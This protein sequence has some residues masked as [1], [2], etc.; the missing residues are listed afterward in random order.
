MTTHK[1]PR[2]R[3]PLARRGTIVAIAAGVGLI[4]PAALSAATDGGPVEAGIVVQKVEGLPDDFAAGVDVSSVLSLEASGVTFRDDDGQVADL[5]DVLAD[6]GVTH[7]RI[8]VWN[9]PWDSE[10]NGYGGGT[11]DVPRAVQIGERATAA[12]LQ[13]LVDFHYSDFWADPA[14]QKA[15]KAWASLDAA[16]TAAAVGTFTTDALTQFKDA[17]VDVTMVQVGNETNNGVAGIACPSAGATTANWAPCAAVYQAGSAA[18]RDVFP[19]ALVAVH[20]TNPENGRY[21]SYAAALDGNHVDYDVFASS[22]YPYWHGTLANLT[23]S[24]KTVA[25]S[26]DKLV[27]VAETSWNYTFDDGD[28]WQNTITTSTTN[29]RYAASVQGQ[30]D[31]LSDVIRAVVDVGPAGIGA[32]W[33]EPAWLPVGPPSALDANKLLWEHDGSGWAASYAGEFDPVDAGQWFGGSSW[34]NQALFDV[35]GNPLGSLR[36]FQYV[37]TGA[38]APRVV[39]QVETVALDLRAGEPVDLPDSVAVTYNDRSVEHPTVYWSGAVSWIR[40]PG[41]YVIP[42][43]TT[44]GIDVTA[45]VDVRAENVVVNPGFEDPD[46]SMWAFSTAVPTIGTDTPFSGAKGVAFWSGSAYS[47]EVTQHIEDVPPGAY[48]L[49]ATTQGTNSPSSDA[50]ELFAT[51]SSGEVSAPLEI[52]GYK[53]W[54]TATVPVQVGDDG[55][56]TVGARFAL[57][58]G[59]WGTL[60][61][62][63]LVPAQPTV[64]V[65]TSALEAVLADA[66]SVDRA[67][68]T[69]ESLAEL[70]EA[71][72][73]AHVVQAGSQ[74]TQQDVDDATAVVQ[75]ALN[76]LV[77][78]P[79]PTPST[80]PSSSPSASATP[81][82]SASPTATASPSATPAP[83]TVTASRTSAHPGDTV[84]ITATGLTVTEVEVGVAST[85][86]KLATVPVVNGTATAT[87]TLPANLPAGVHHVQ[88]R[89]VTTGEVLAQVEITVTAASSGTLAATGAQIEGI[90][91]LA[92]VLVLAGTAAV[93]VRRRRLSG[94]A[95]TH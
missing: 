41:T 62:V 73:V 56:V 10:G 53:E 39:T 46:T 69:P 48:V 37:R 40:G 60:D 12:G 44:T 38:T 76:G 30:A 84:T 77:A 50:R 61:E 92:G 79:E 87:V 23:S 91:A 18:A 78:V 14:K 80:S 35:E 28:G 5:F 13:V 42:G 59:A 45:T 3:S 15:P 68:W 7:V 24:L 83:P 4:A 55:V 36:T 26:Y 57:S 51:T 58:A 75:V 67:A 74:A 85:Y 82:A 6:H 65:D 11:V 32:F 90:L 89:N 20:F 31:E 34:D 95:V 17:G 63:R 71:V 27:M 81:S 47:F 49:S 94:G 9:D 43:R 33:W 66:A 21:P 25:D 29:N 88:L 1:R 8:R 86:Q 22:Y 2:P 93:A 54:R 16:Q 19:D 64:S 70:D 52:A 72:A